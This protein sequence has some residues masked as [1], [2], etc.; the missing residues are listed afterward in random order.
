MVGLCIQ[1]Q[2]RS[3]SVACVVRSLIQRLKEIKNAPVKLTIGNVLEVNIY[4]P[5]KHIHVDIQANNKRRHYTLIRS[6]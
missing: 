6:K 4:K 2:K 5:G 1:K 3:D